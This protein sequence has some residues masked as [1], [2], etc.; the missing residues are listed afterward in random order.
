MNFVYSK[1]KP[2]S[3]FIWRYNNNIN[4]SNIFILQNYVQNKENV[5]TESCILKLKW[6]MD[7]WLIGGYV[8]TLA[9]LTQL[10]FFNVMTYS[11]L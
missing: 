3:N 11:K 1:K 9:P 6:F 10:F 2:N 5:Y 7:D 8:I 4:D